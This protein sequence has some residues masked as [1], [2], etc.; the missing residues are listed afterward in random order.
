MNVNS[1]FIFELQVVATIRLLV[2]ATKSETDIVGIFLLL[3]QTVGQQQQLEPIG[4]TV[5]SFFCFVWSGAI[6]ARNRP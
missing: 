1:I 3:A 4:F 5:S 2:P 6:V